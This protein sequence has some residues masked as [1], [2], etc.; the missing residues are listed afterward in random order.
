VTSESELE[1]ALHRQ[2]QMVDEVRKL[3][4]TSRRLAEILGIVVI[5]LA[6]VALLA[7]ISLRASHEARD[8]QARIEVIIADNKA[9]AERTALQ[10]CLLR[11]NTPRALREGANADI[12]ATAEL[13][14]GA[15][16]PQADIDRYV[17]ARRKAIPPIGVTDR[18]CNGDGRITPDDYPAD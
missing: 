8:A 6:A 11:N 2:E 15:G 9:A 1:A 17:A 12:D 4:I 5:V 14:Q 18:D 13:L 10:A 16:T 3:R 7:V